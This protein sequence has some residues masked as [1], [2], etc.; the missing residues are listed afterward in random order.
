MAKEEDREG[1]GRMGSQEGEAR[2]RSG[3]EEATDTSGGGARRPAQDLD[4]ADSR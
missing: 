1:P 2:I 3:S 4:E